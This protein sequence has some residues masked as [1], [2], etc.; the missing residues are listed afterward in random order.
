MTTAAIDLIPGDWTPADL[1]SAILNGFWSKFAEVTTEG[2]AWV[3]HSL[4]SFMD[5]STRPDLT[6]DWFSGVGSPV[7]VM[8]NIAAPV[9][10][11][12]LIIGVI[13]A[14]FSGAGIGEMVRRGF[15]LPIVAGLMWVAG[16]AVAQLLIDA[17]RWMTFTIAGNSA[18][19]GAGPGAALDRM[20]TLVQL[21]SGIPPMAI[22]PIASVCI[23][24]GFFVWMEL[25]IS[26]A[27]IYMAMLFFPLSLAA[28]LWAPAAPM[29]RHLVHFVVGLI[30]FPFIIT[31]VIALASA[32]LVSPLTGSNAT[33]IV[34]VLGGE[35]TLALAC[36]A[37]FLVMRWVPVAVSA[38][39]PSA[40]RHLL[41]RVHH[42]LP[43]RRQ[44]TSTIVR[45]TAKEGRKETTGVRGT[46]AGAA[47]HVA[48]SNA[49]VVGRSDSRTDA[50][51]PTGASRPAG[52]P[53]PSSWKPEARQPEA[54]RQRAAAAAAARSSRAEPEKVPAR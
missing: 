24:L 53:R 42:S 15:V 52:A 45:S 47:H 50:T 22:I 4:A 21:E 13:H 38:A 16:I 14:L 3:L 54:A 8:R 30:F 31:S 20:A 23:V 32:S 36:V 37:P 10:L 17:V 49:G 35:A 9:A 41:S 11:L 18:Q 46:S 29:L 33:N 40:G 2:A 26:N 34:V 51:R 44:D 27:A 48:R 19:P 7:Y 25:V 6:A 5:T 43:Y 28:L 12:F 39:A 1:A